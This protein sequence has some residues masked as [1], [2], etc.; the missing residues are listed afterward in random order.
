MKNLLIFP[1][2]FIVL[3]SRAQTEKTFTE[4]LDGIQT[5]SK[6]L[7]KSASTDNSS[8]G[9]SG[10]MATSLP[11]V[12]VSSR[13][14]N[15]PI[16]LNYTSGIKVDQ[17]SGPVGL[18]WVMPVGSIVRDYGAFEP[19]YTSTLHEGDMKQWDGVGQTGWLNPNGGGDAIDPTKNNQYLGYDALVGE[20]LRQIPL[21]DFYHMS[22]PG[23]GSNTFWNGGPIGASHIW[24]WT[25][26][27][28][29]R[30]EHE[31][32][33]YQI[34]QEFS[35]V[36][37]ANLDNPGLGGSGKDW[38]PLNE[39]YAAAIG[40]L[41]Y[42][43]H[44]ES[45]R[46]LAGTGSFI[47]TGGEK[48]VKY[49]DFGKFT[50]TDE[51]GTKYVFGRA[52]RGQKFVLQDDPYWS[53][54]SND[55][56]NAADG[57]FWKI[58][59]IAEWLLTEILSADYED[60]NN[61]GIA[62]DED[63]GD[64]IR[65][66]Y[67]KPTKTI[68]TIP[69]GANPNLRLLSDVPTHRE[70]SSFSQTDQA[71][72]LM[73]ERAYLAKII[74]PV[75]ELD[76]TISKRFDVDHDYY[77]KPAN[78]IG[79]DFFYEDRQYGTQ[80][81]STDFD[82]IYP[83][84]TMKYDT[85]K[86]YSRLIDKAIYSDENTLTGAI[87]FNYAAKGSSEELAVSEYLI[88]NNN[89]EDKLIDKPS[90]SSDFNIESYKGGD[91]RGKTTL[92]S[93]DL[94]GG[95]MDEQK[96]NLYEF[97]Y[98]YNPSYNEVHKRKIVRSY[99][100]PSLRNSKS[101]SDYP[102][103]S[104]YISYSEER[105]AADGE[106]YSTISHTGVNGKL[107]PD[108][109]LIDIPYK[110]VH[111]KLTFAN[112][113]DIFTYAA[114]GNTGPDGLTPQAYPIQHSLAPLK[115]VYGFLYSDNCEKCPKAWS[116]TSIT[117]P[118]GGRVSFEYESGEFEALTDQP[119]WSLTENNVPV[120][121]EYNELAKHR[122][123]VQDAYNQYAGLVSAEGFG[124]NADRYKTLTATFEVDLPTSYGIRLKRKTIYDRVNP[125]VEISYDY[126]NGHFTSLPAEYVQS[127]VGAFNQFVIR[128]KNRHSWEMGHYGNSPGANFI[129]DYQN[130]MS[131]S[132]I[133]DIALD[134]Y[135]ATH[136]YESIDEKNAD[137]S[138]T[139]N[140]YGK[141]DG[142]GT[143]DYPKYNIFCYRLPGVGFGWDGRFIL[144]RENLDALPIMPLK[145]EMF[146]AN[147]QLPYS[148][149]THVY[150]R[151]KII[152]HEISFDYTGQNPANPNPNYVNMWGLLDYY[153]I[154][155]PATQGFWS[156][157]YEYDNSL[158]LTFP[159]LQTGV[160]GFGYIPSQIQ[161]SFHIPY[162]GIPVFEYTRWG[163]F[164]T[165][166]LSV[167]TDYKGMV[168]NVEYEYNT[169]NQISKKTEYGDFT[170][171]QYI[172]T[173]EYAHE[174]Y[175]SVNPNPF[176]EHNML[177]PQT[178]IRSFLGSNSLDN[179]TRAEMT[180]YDITNYSIPRILKSYVYEVDVEPSTGKFN[181]TGNEFVIG[182]TNANWRVSQNDQ[183]AYNKPGALMSSRTNRL[184]NKTVFGNNLGVV[185][186]SIDHPFME[187][188]ATYSGFEDFQDVHVISTWNNQ[189]YKDEDWFIEGEPSLNEPA[190]SW[191]VDENPC[192]NPIPAGENQPMIKELNHVLID[193]LT[194]IQPGD[195]VK[196]ELKG[197][198]NSIPTNYSWETEAIVSSIETVPSFYAKNFALCLTVPIEYPDGV[199]STTPP[200]MGDGLDGTPVPIEL[201]ERAEYTITE[202]KVT[203]LEDT[204]NVSNRFARTGKYSYRLP[205]KRNANDVF[206][207]TP[208]RPVKLEAP[209]PNTGAPG[210]PGIACLDPNLTP[211]INDECQWSYEASVWLKMELDHTLEEQQSGVSKSADNLGDALYP[212][213]ILSTT[214]TGQGIKIVCDL[215]NGD[216][217]SVIETRVFYP[218]DISSIWKQYTINVPF[219][220]G[221]LR[222]LD[223][224]V[225]NE[226][227]QTGG[228]IDQMK[229]LY[230]DDILIY[231]TGAKYN[232]SVFDKFGNTTHLINNDDVVVEAAFDEKGRPVMQK[233]A[234]G[235]LVSEQS[236][237][238]TPNWSNQ[239]NHVTERSWVKNA[240]YNEKRYYLDG[241]GKTKQV[242]LADHTKGARIVSETNYYNNRG[243]VTASFKPYAIS[244]ALF[245]DNFDTDFITEVQDMYSSN[246]ALTEATYE[247]KPEMKVSTMSS[248]RMNTE[249]P[250]TASQ[251]DYT[252]PTP[253]VAPYGLT[254]QTQNYPAGQLL[255]H[256]VTNANGNKVR[257][258][259]DNLGRVILEEHEIGAAHVQ[260]SNGTISTTTGNSIAKTWF[261]YDAV[262]RIVKVVD[263]SG[264][265]TS[266]VYNSL[267]VIVE[268]NVADQG[269]SQMRY[270]K[271]GQI[272]FI[273]DQKDIDA[274]AGSSFGTDQFSYTKYDEWGRIVEAGQ[275]MVATSQPPYT[276]VTYFD[277]YSKINDPNFPANSD[278]LFQIHHEYDFDGSRDQFNSNSL[279][280]ETVYDNHVLS[281]NFVYSAGVKDETEYEYMADGQ[282]AKTRYN[283]DGLSEH[284]I[285]YEYNDIQLPVGKKYT[286]PTQS[287]FNFEWKTELDNFARPKS[288]SSIHNGATTQT[289]AYYYDV[290][291]N[292]LMKGIGTTGD[293]NDPHI[294]YCVFKRNIRDQI[295]NYT[296]KNFRFGLA[297]DLHGNILDQFWSN[298]LL[299]PT[300]VSNPSI[301]QYHYYYDKMNRLIGADYRSGTSSGNPFDYF[302]NIYST[303]PNDF[304]CGVNQEAVDNYFTNVTRLV[305]GSSRLGAN[306]VNALNELNAGY[307]E[308]NVAYQSMSEEDK[309][310]FINSY[311]STMNSKRLDPKAYE[312]YKASEEQDGAHK[313]LIAN[314]RNLDASV[315]K[316]TKFVLRDIPFTPS[317][318]CDP[319][320]NATVYG[321]LPEFPLPSSQTNGSKYDAAYWYAENGN[322]VQLNRN[323]DQGV[324]TEQGYAYSNPTSNQLTQTNFTTNNAT[325]THG[326][327][328]DACGN[329]TSDGLTGVSSISYDDFDELPKTMVNSGS[330]KSYRYGASGK[331]I[332]KDVGTTDKEYYFDGVIV[333]VNGNVKSY[334]TPEGYVV[335]SGVSVNYFYYAQDWLGTTRGVMNYSGQIQNAH[336]H[337][338][339]GKLMPGRISIS[340]NEGKRYQFTGHEFDD[341]TGYGY[342]GARYYNR[343]LGRYM[344]VDPVTKYHESPYVYAANG[345]TMYVDVNGEDTVLFEKTSGKPIG[346]KISDSEK[347]VIYVVDGLADNFD[348]ENPWELATPLVYKIGKSTVNKGISG[349][350]FRDDHPLKDIGTKAGSQVYLEDLL[351]LS[352]E[353]SNI[354]RAGISGH[355]KLTPVPE[356][357]KMPVFRRLW[358]DDAVYDLKST[359][360]DVT[361]SYAAKVIGE[362]SI[363]NG[364][365]RKYDDYGNI[366]YGFLGK[367]AGFSDFTLKGASN[368]NQALKD[369]SGKTSGSGGDDIRDVFTIGQGIKLYED[370]LNKGK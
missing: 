205:T 296:S 75:Q 137:N 164:E 152:D 175:L 243:F 124:Q 130:R 173:Y 213:G 89:N 312:L 224:Y 358:T 20:D 21:S 64:W 13:T 332:V 233:N 5:S 28:N 169:K 31:A 74:T 200:L 362:W 248:P 284:V 155:L 106:S 337:Y 294:D 219:S 290:L 278:K 289:G 298:E 286:H 364:H 208:I 336:D 183:I 228:N 27:E 117:Y 317:I 141:L 301:H 93:V 133:T 140:H 53:V 244:G 321:F 69:Y 46:P 120:I 66:E 101:S 62:D 2:A 368:I 355:L 342:H 54:Q 344:N 366:A 125:S 41:P 132:A 105:L 249:A 241:F 113:L 77:S 258:Y 341:E 242:M 100:Y 303:I 199:F 94:L 3:I 330:I 71:S 212:D 82:I 235:K 10:I 283:F 108:N 144:A 90:T 156:G 260:N 162:N 265:Q 58:D 300:D 29:W 35:R 30:I 237:F 268:K 280:K 163:S 177:S 291:G 128:E 176:L 143:I 15:F 306:A 161:S 76:F 81:N 36:N 180:T 238:D 110:E 59:F 22:I 147:E 171:E 65:F 361:P 217:T 246:H 285:E 80:G 201:D 339:F 225:V 252:S 18:G 95:D 139:R 293:N 256:E 68:G 245:S 43:R 97:Q 57:S 23:M 274:N 114:S 202:T 33:V 203:K 197:N 150:E 167:K 316:Y 223:V 295:V 346:R 234:Y 109:F 302:D 138:F 84:E 166:Q 334:Q 16:Q 159:A 85:I 157:N 193:N 61:N 123:Y 232:Y 326:Y 347:T 231:P 131:H 357:L 111:Y 359:K 309:S 369:M 55:E 103:S 310:D 323:D 322:L 186:A 151:E 251:Q 335:P 178:R 191:H 96:K 34:N 78:K 230:A 107:H 91:K 315:M 9:Q 174:T 153:Q 209:F 273:R 136:F 239:V 304:S 277:D 262:G 338:P 353:F 325:T 170:S 158:T 87:A 343:E 271:Y 86:I 39:S 92:L 12:T 319:N 367:V 267:G 116:L 42:V 8:V 79:N 279:I 102:K 129:T 263:P 17:K 168:S 24:K 38:F 226:I 6:E 365:L 227:D 352:D 266:Y 221:G 142:S 189:D 26:Y 83:V 206:V 185:K 115:D 11:L 184:F 282:L 253:I 67:T 363:S 19:D 360:N 127:Y 188:D 313:D 88:R 187:F 240:T 288:N 320:L 275:K 195:K 247:P 40:L 210:T 51:N 308:N 215:Y 324:K 196:L 328:Y 269:T 49:E 154:W 207:K 7:T 122:S 250:I 218:E 48:F 254:I 190:I 214:N 305:D 1:F 148:S 329:I 165:R 37:D 146:E 276:G 331:R 73:R 126:T 272:R 264:K 194:G 179:V 216:R 32:K 318:D 257:T 349:K 104:A 348:S 145:T 292:M 307:T 297:Y 72:S 270:D 198:S 70:W 350:S 255:I 4:K 236:Y 134:E 99:S 340:D 311:I 204:Y 98:A 287:S 259:M 52:L 50:I 229:S 356:L 121:K 333:D 222:W 181:L 47:P 299:D 351:D 14:M 60:L 345:P 261:V 220:K 182:G 45:K 44:G 25:E 149:V 327:T 118:T 172:T 192:S 160:V 314:A 370:F 354:L 211:M 281:A 119:N 56:P 135:Q 112:D 63:A